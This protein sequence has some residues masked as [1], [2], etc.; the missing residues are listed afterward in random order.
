MT[1]KHFSPTLI[2]QQPQLDQ[3]CA[4]LESQQILYVDTEFVRVKTYKP[5]LGL[6]Q[7]AFADNTACIDPL[8]N[9]NLDTFWQ[10]LL[11]PQR[12]KVLHSS[13]QDIEVIFFDQQNIL[14]PLFDTQI[15]AG[16]LGLPPQIGYASLVK[17][18]LDIE[19]SKS[20]TRTDWSR[21]PLTEAQLDYATEDVIYLP[22]LHDLLYSQLETSGRLDWAIED[23]ADIC[24]E[25]LYAVDTAAAWQRIKSIPFLAPAEQL[26]AQR[27]AAWREKRALDVDKP[28]QWI[29]DDKAILQLAAANPASP[30]GISD[31]SAVPAGL[32]KKQGETILE[33][34]HQANE[35]FANGVVNPLQVPKPETRETAE[36]KRLAKLVRARAEELNLAPEIIASKREITELFRGGRST[37]QLNGWRNEVIGQELL[38]AL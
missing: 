14:Q 17:E 4:Q 15:A 30:A 20:Q 27:L 16:L 11:D 31:C 18:L 21:R 37:R 25:E 26:R 3:L 6:I 32:A 12:K 19:I 38:A 24:R 36:I 10:L 9:L 13:K 2:E 1:P 8:C 28:R 5:H 22:E 7:L 33:L 35:D 29:I 23:S 34:V